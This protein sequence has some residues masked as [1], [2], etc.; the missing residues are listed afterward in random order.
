M[1]STSL[2]GTEWLPDQFSHLLQTLER[3]ES[4]SYILDTQFRIM[5]CNPS[6]NRFVECNGAAEC[7][8]EEAVGSDFIGMFPETVKA[9]HSNALSHVLSTREVWEVSY[10]CS[11][12]ALFCMHR[13]R[14][15]L[16]KPQ[17]WFLVTNALHA[18][19]GKHEANGYANSGVVSICARCRCTRRVD[20]PNQ[21]DFV[22]EYTEPRLNYA[23]I[24]R[25]EMCPICSAYL[26]FEANSSS[27]QKRSSG[28]RNV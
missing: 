15:Q 13:M 24:G 25:E 19:S 14:I 8:R 12:P 3:S 10:E 28:Q 7:T 9:F 21:W 23:I 11:D 20:N 26:S 5:Y 6:W 22:P 18:N 17:N 1:A 27:P 2:G 16:L 4:S